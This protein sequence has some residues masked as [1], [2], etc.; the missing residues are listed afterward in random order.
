VL[1]SITAIDDITSATAITRERR[2][3]NIYTLIKIYH[4][5]G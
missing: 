2:S 1:D 4:V 5:Q 3:L